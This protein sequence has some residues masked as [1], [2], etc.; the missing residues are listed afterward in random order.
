LLVD[1]PT[2][3]TILSQPYGGV[4]PVGGYFN[5]SVVA[6]G[7]LPLSYQWFFES[8]AIAGATNRNLALNNV[9]TNDGGAYTVRVQTLSSTV[10]SL[11]AV[12]TVTTSD[13]GGGTIDFRNKFGGVVTNG[14][15][16]FDLDGVT[17]LNGSNYVAQLYAGPSLALLRPAGQPTPFQSGFNAGYFYSQIITLANVPPGGN[18]VVQ[19]RAWDVAF[20][21][22]YEEVRALGGRVGKS[23]VLQVAAG[24]NALPAAPLTGLQSFSLQAGLPYFQVGT[25]SFVERQPHNLIIWA[26]HGQPGYLYSIEKLDRRNSTIWQPYTIVTNVTGTVNFSD[27]ANSGSAVV[28]YRGRILD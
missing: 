11:P 15:P 27:S 22:S 17:P 14:A 2:S 7:T 13:I 8:N 24:G 9:R 21:T 12:L 28:F 4:V 5:F 20:G 10:W 3:A 1:A 6:A 23:Q 18:A 26:L 16:V 19:V 25:I